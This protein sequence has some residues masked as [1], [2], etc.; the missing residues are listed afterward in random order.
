[1]TKK[2]RPAA[3]CGSFLVRGGDHPT[4][5]KFTVAY[6][7]TNFDGWVVTL[8]KRNQHDPGRVL[9]RSSTI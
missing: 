1:M 5:V 3:P 2:G 4:E 9:L 8:Q 7:R 6:K